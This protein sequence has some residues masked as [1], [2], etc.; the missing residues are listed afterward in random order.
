MSSTKD[1]FAPAHPQG[2]ICASFCC[3]AKAAK[4]L[5]TRRYGYTRR[6]TAVRAP[7]TV[8]QLFLS[9]CVQ[10]VRP[11]KILLDMEISLGTGS[12]MLRDDVSTVFRNIQDGDS[13]HF[14]WK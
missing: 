12:Y 6:G 7:N 8:C 9:R 5:Q 13:H 3:T 11:A 1:T 2:G 14:R 4:M 10:M